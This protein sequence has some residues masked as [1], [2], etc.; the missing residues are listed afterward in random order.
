MA[1]LIGTS[2]WHYRHWVGS[3]YP[4]KTPPR[5]FLERY[6]K[7]FSTVEINNSFY[8]LPERETFESWRD[9]VPASFHFAV[10]ASRYI[11]HFKKLKESGDSFRL[12]FERVSALGPRLGPILFQLPPHWHFDGGRLAGFLASL[13]RGPR[14]VFE[15]RD[16]DWYRD[17]TFGLLDRFR[18]GFCIHDLPDSASPEIVTGKIAYVRFHGPTGKYQGSYTDGDLARWAERMREW[19]ARRIPV[20][21][22]FNNDIGGHAPRNAITLQSMLKV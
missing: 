9:A 12:F 19:S 13:P 7:D 6:L 17:E 22:Y 14:Y 4:P 2:G 21:A 16:R 20:F 18:A 10:K 8:R 5:L 3:F 1:L 11:T 15:F